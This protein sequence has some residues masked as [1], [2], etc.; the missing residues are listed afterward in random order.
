MLVVSVDRRAVP[1]EEL[2]PPDL[3]SP[4][5]SRVRRVRWRDP[6]LWLGILLVAAS[7]LLGARLLASSDDTVPVWAMESDGVAGMEVSA[8][9]V[10]LVEVRFTDAADAERYLPADVAFPAEQRLVHD[11]GAGELLAADAVSAD[12]AV[13]PQLPLGVAAA[14]LP[15]DLAPGD[16]VDVWAQTAEQ[17][18]AGSRLLIAEASVVSVDGAETAGVGGDRQ[19]LV[20]LPDAT[21]VA[22]VLDGLSGATVVLLRVG[23]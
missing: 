6:R 16:V 19:V 3:T 2:R 20:A 7:V 12:E 10:R 14:G 22:D 9:Q 23:D 13:A 11:V 18:R 21:D 1:V 15:S 5:A 17:T 8:G 4:S